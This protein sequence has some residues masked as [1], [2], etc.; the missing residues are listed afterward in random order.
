LENKE[1]GCINKEDSEQ[2]GIE[3][4]GFLSQNRHWKTTLQD[5]QNALK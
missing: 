3:R 1:V 2:G 5:Y 4:L